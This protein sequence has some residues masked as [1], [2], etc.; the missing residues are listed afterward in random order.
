MNGVDSFP[1]QDVAAGPNENE[2]LRPGVQPKTG[3]KHLERNFVAFRM[4]PKHRL[5]KVAFEIDVVL[6]P[7]RA[8]C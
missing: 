2:P 1:D 3:A 4:A 5:Q 6:R 7:M 8:H